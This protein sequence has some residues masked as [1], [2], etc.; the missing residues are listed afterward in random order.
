MTRPCYCLAGGPRP[1]RVHDP[2]AIAQTSEAGLDA[3]RSGSRIVAVSG[4]RSSRLHLRRPGNRLR[5]GHRPLRLFRR[6][7][8]TTNVRARRH[9]MQCGPS[10]KA[11]STKPSIVGPELIATVALIKLTPEAIRLQAVPLRALWRQCDKV[12]SSLVR[13]PWQPPFSIAPRLH[14][15]WS[16]TALV[17]VTNRYEPIGSRRASADTTDCFR[18]YIDQPMQ[19]RVFRSST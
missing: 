7:S 19:L 3:E 11:C 10:P 2:S 17:S 4:P 8:P 18:L 14:P 15:H 6:P 16:R 9:I 12:R 13:W 1:R 5:S